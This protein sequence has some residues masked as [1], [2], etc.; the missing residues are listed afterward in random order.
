[1]QKQRVKLFINF[2]QIYCNTR[3]ILLISTIL[4]LYFLTSLFYGINVFVVFNYSSHIYRALN[5]H[6]KAG[7]FHL[8]I[9]NFI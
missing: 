7:K 3:F 6:G 2:Q 4:A 1:M 5:T 8:L 9:Y